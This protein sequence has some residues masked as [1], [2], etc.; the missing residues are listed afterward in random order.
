MVAQAEVAPHPG[1]LLLGWVG[2]SW[3][4]AHV[5]GYF[6]AV[7]ITLVLAGSLIVVVGVTIGP[8]LPGWLLPAGI[9]GVAV[10]ELITPLV[11]LQTSHPYASGVAWLIGTVLAGLA[12]AA[13]GLLLLG[14]GRGH[15]AAG[16]V[17]LV[18]GAIALAGDACVVGSAPDP[19]IDVWTLL[20]ASA[21][22]L[23]HGQD[24]YR[25]T[26]PHSTGLTDVYPY[27]P[28]STLLT[29][30]AWAIFG[31]VR[32]ADLV[33]LPVAAIL[34]WRLRQT[35]M[36]TSRLARAT[37]VLALA[38]V[39]YPRATLVPQDAYTEPLLLVL[40]IAM[41]A[42]VLGGHPTLAV[43]FLAL[44]L[45]SKQ[46]IAL[47]LPVAAWWPAFGWRRTL[48][49]TGLGIGIVS[50]WLIAGPGALW[51]DAVISTLDF[52][53]L[54]T[55]LDVPALL[56]HHGIVVGFALTAAGLLGAYLVIGLRV[57]RT[58]QGFVTGCALVLL[59]VDLTNKQTFFNHWSLV[60]GLLIVAVVLHGQAKPA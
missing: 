59:A 52:P 33:A 7:S 45:A 46:H 24:L 43:I 20:Q 5:N 15:R 13:T 1:A 38:L 58:A 35:G 36:A 47:L 48:A 40:L 42:S 31:D 56:A 16:A 37:P 12:T 51:H 57:A 55:A 9:G 6:S 54:R 23:V 28:G 41:V 34:C 44:A 21:S 60:T 49:A 17:L 4:I 53:V 30:P 10:L 39:A 8:R 18:V 19:G 29:F 25:Q 32:A 26:W 11:H 50:P 14:T 22:G 2:L 27:L 3:G